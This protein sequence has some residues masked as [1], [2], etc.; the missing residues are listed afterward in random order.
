MK[1]RLL[2]FLI[3]I[4]SVVSGNGQTNIYHP[5]PDS[6]FWRV[7]YHYDKQFLGPCYAD[8]YFQYSSKGDTIINSS[9]YK[10]IYRSGVRVD[11][12]F[13]TDPHYV[14]GTPASGYVGALKDDSVANKTFFVFANT[15]TDS[16]LYDYNLVV[17]DTVRGQIGEASCYSICHLVVLSIDSVLINGQYRKKWHFANEP[18][19]NDSS[20]FIEGVGSSSGLIEQLNT[21]QYDLTYRHLICVKD[22]SITYFASNAYSVVGCNLIY[23]GISESNVVNNFSISPN[24]FSNETTLKTDYE[25][26]N[27]T[28]TITNVFG[29]EV[30]QIKNSTGKEI[31]L[32]RDNLPTGIY[33]IQLSENDKVIATNKIIISD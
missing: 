14:P 25:L 28:L 11:T 30:K 13:C 12:L 19:N 1:K 2:A 16:L 29:Q 6:V 21:S 10:K 22:S 15:T 27:A 26:K 31:K 4:L 7:D 33:F 8:Y 9:V 3:L 23:T 5:F 32:H 24:P 20:Y 18:I 17:G